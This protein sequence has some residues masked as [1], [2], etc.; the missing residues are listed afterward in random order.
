MEAD[1][2]EAELGGRDVGVDGFARTGVGDA[3]MRTA[4]SIWSEGGLVT[5]AVGTGAGAAV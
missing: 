1:V 4:V 5:D 3:L 2:K